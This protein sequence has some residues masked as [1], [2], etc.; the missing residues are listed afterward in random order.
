MQTIGYGHA[1]QPE[2]SCNNIKAPIS[3]ETGDQLLRG[4]AQKAVDCV[5]GNVKTS[6]TQNQFD[7]SVSFTFNLGCGGFQE[8]VGEINARNFQEATRQWLL[9]VHAGGDP[10][11]VP[12]LVRR[13]REEVDLFNKP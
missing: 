10:N 5:K 11:P 1:C 6:L 2:S 12:G 4:D 7:A 3:R 13:R 8:I 9:Y